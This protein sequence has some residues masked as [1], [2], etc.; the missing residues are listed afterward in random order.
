MHTELVNYDTFCNK[1]MFLMRLC[2]ASF[3]QRIE[4]MLTMAEFTNVLD[5]LKPAIEAV[6]SNANGKLL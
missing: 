2:V 3:R 1:F 4:A 6:M 5:W